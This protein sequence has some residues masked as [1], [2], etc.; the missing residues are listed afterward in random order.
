MK[1]IIRGIAPLVGVLLLVLSLTGSAFAA[2]KY[3]ALGDSYSAGYGA[4]SSNLDSSCGRNTYAYPYLVAQQKAYTLNFVACGGAV[5]GDVINNQIP[6]IASD[7]KV[8]TMTIGGNDIGFV[9]LILAC[10]TLGCSSQIA[11]S[12]N[13]INTQL[14]AKLNATYAAIKAKAPSA[15]V[16]ILGYGRP[17]AS[18]SRTCLSATGVSSS[19]EVSLNALVDSLNNTIKARAQ[20][21]GFSYADPN[22]YWSGHDVCSSNPFTNG[23][24]ILHSSDSYHPTRNG[25]SA[26]YTPLVRSI[27]G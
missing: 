24:T 19:E 26:G 13:Q 17:F 22:P 8:V 14:P 20:A 3:S 12:Q 6:T 11:S 16:V 23:L 18:P 7:T 25:Y 9:N 2:D 4:N 1:R 5:T 27:V 15:K 10:T 21:Y